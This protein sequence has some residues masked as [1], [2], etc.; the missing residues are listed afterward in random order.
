MSQNKN[1]STLIWGATALGALG[2]VATYAAAGPERFW[3][4]WILWFVLM[5]YSNL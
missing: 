4:N 2:V 3:A 1:T 5:Y